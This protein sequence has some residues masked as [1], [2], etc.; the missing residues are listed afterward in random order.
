MQRGVY[1]VMIATEFITSVTHNIYLRIVVYP[2]CAVLFHCFWTFQKHIFMTDA[3]EQRLASLI[4]QGSFYEAEQLCIA[5]HHRLQRVGKKQEALDCLVNGARELAKV[6]QFQCALVLLDKAQEYMKKQNFSEESL[7]L[8]VTLLG[9]FPNHMKAK[10]T[11]LGKLEKYASE[12]HYSEHILHELYELMAE[13]CV[14]IGDYRRALRYY[15]FLFDCNRY[16]WVLEQWMSQ[17][18]YS[19]QDL[20]VTRQVLR[21]ITQGKK[22]MAKQVLGLCLQKHEQL[23]TSPLIGFLHIFLECL[24]RNLFSSLE[25][26]TNIYQSAFDRD[27]HLRKCLHDAIEYS[28]KTSI[29]Q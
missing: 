3:P 16:A 28:K 24:E 27:P 12:R 9:S 26:L 11:L 19:E 2:T 5:L 25:L 4:E 1:K 13:T 14:G 8:I 21:L 10:F 29:K 23:N 17:G 6:E 15:S 18:L 20:F 7:S 22:E